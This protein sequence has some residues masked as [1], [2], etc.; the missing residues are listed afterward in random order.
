MNCLYR[1]VPPLIS[2]RSEETFLVRVGVVEE[3]LV[4]VQE[5]VQ[6]EVV[7]EEVVEFVISL[8]E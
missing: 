1:N 4:L 5:V 3:G 8:P 7:V 6:R 2:S